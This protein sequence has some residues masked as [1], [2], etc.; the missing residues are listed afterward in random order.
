MRQQDRC[1]GPLGRRVAPGGPAAGGAARVSRPRLRGRVAPRGGRPRVRARTR[2]AP[3]LRRSGGDAALARVRG[4]PSSAWRSLAGAG[5]RT[6]AALLRASVAVVAGAAARRGLR[7]RRP[8]AVRRQALRRPGGPDDRALRPLRQQEPLR[9]LRRARGLPRARA[10]GRARRRG[11]ARARAAEL[12]REPARRVGRRRLGRGGGARPRRSRVALARRRREP[13]G[14]DR[15][16]RRDPAL[17]AAG[18][19]HRGARRLL[20]AA[21]GLVIAVVALAP[22]SCPTRHARACARSATSTAAGR[23]PP[24]RVARRAA[25]LRLE[26][27][28]GQRPRR[29]RGRAAALQDGRRGPCASST[30][31][32]TTSSCCARAGSSGSVSRWSRPLARCSSA[33]WRAIRDEPHRL[34]RGVACGALAGALRP[35]RPQ[36]LRLQP[37]HPLERAARRAAGG[38]RPAPARP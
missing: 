21:C 25:A 17:D 11:T 37:A 34:A 28:R 20:L 9:R 15:R 30:P 38:V 33:G 5:L 7:P 3:R 29:V 13:R 26:P 14:R 4:R 36:R 12:A 8:A 16:L 10:R 1:L 24:R 31:R 22:C 19:R 27:R 35:A 32:T 23:L 18:P 2:T 6:R